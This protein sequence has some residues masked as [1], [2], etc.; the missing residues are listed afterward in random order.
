MFTGGLDLDSDLTTLGNVATLGSSTS[1]VAVKVELETATG[2]W[3]LYVR[4]LSGSG[5]GAFGD[6]FD[7]RG[8]DLAAQ[9]GLNGLAA[10]FMLA[11]PAGVGQRRHIDLDADPVAV[12]VVRET[13]RFLGAGIGALLN[14]LNPEVVVLAGGVVNA[15]EALFGPLKAEVRRRAFAP[16]VDACRIVP[17]ELGGSAGVVGAVAGFKA[18]VGIVT[19]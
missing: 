10:F 9:R 15:G 6:V 13:A 14:V 2:I 16:A 12:D 18:Q 4:E 17:G 11:H 7:V 5:I 1:S 19:T 8:A 3:R